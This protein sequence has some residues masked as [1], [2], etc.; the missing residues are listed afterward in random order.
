VGYVRCGQEQ[1]PL[2]ASSQV[3]GEFSMR[4]NA[5]AVRLA[6]HEAGASAVS[7]PG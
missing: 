2:E 3:S 6:K 1:L 7:G 5:A 4:G